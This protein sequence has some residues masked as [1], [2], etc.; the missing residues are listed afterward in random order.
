M[1]KSF[2][3]KHCFII[4]LLSILACQKE[5]SSYGIANIYMPQ[6]VNAT[7][8]VS[9]NYAVPAGTDSSTYNYKIETSSNLLSITLGAARS[10]TTAND[11]FAVD[12][13][14]D[15]DTIALLQFNSILDNT[16][17][18][19]PASMYT[20]PTVLSVPSGKSEGTFSLSIN[21]DSL[22]SPAYE[23][24]KLVLAVRLKSTGKYAVVPNASTTIVI[25]DVDALVIGPTYDI[26]AQYLRN[27]SQP[28]ATSGM[29][30]GGRWGTLSD[31]MANNAA[32]SHNGYGG[33]N[34]NDGGSINMETGWGSPAIH[35]GKI[36]QTT[37]SPLPAGTYTFNVPDFEWEGTKDPTY[38]VVAPGLDTIPDYA[39]IAGNSSIHYTLLSSPVI[40]FQLT[41]PTKVTVGF[42]ADYI[43]DE[44]GFNI[45]SVKLMNY[46]KHL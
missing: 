44:Q 14:T 25:V 7:G 33:Y 42:A 19:M 11:G 27:T 34:S 18:L 32:K 40:T 3:M 2:N 36:W 22:K 28:F 16:T 12:I 1:V 13:M 41:E 5:K 39:D 31:W 10:S 26:S 35:N 38:I 45:N 24:K 20:M 15:P 17:L 46:P 23:G 43:K 21:I 30:A 4:F 37:S 6:S 29:H 9:A 8:G